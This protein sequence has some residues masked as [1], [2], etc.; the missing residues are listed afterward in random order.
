MVASRQHRISIGT[1][2]DPNTR[3]GKRLRKLAPLLDRVLG[4]HKLDD[5][6][7]K[8]GLSGLSAADFADQSL[9]A[10]DVEVIGGDSL[11]QRL[12]KTGPVIIVSNHPHGG[13][14]GLVLIKLLTALRPDSRIL[15]NFALKVFPELE[16][17]FLFVN[18]LIPSDPANRTGLR[19]SL[20]HLQDDGVL[21][22]FPAGRTSFYQDDLDCIAD[23]DWSRSVATLARKSGASVM[24]IRFTGLNSPLFY[25]LGSVW[26]RFRLLMLARELIKM[27]SRRIEVAVGAAAPTKKLLRYDDTEITEM[28]RVLSASLNMP[29]EQLERHQALEHAP[30][31]AG[32]CGKTIQK[33][34]EG[35][36]RHQQS[37]R[38]HGMVVGFARRAEIPEL[39][40]Q[41]MRD[42]ERTFRL[43]DE[44]SGESEDSDH[45]DDS[46]DHIFCWD[47]HNK[48]LVGAYRV[49]RG[50]PAAEGEPTYLHSVFQFEN[51]FF[52]NYNA[53]LELGRSFITPEYQ[54]SRHALDLLWRGIGSYLKAHPE[55][56]ALYGT[57]SLTQQYDSVSVQM[58][59]D[60]LIEPSSQVRPKFPLANR[61]PAEWYRFRRN[62]VIDLAKLNALVSARETDG[63]GVPVLL[64]H[65]AGL[66]AR[67]HAVGIDKQFADTPGLLLS[68]DLNQLPASKRKRYLT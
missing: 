2:A 64:R 18:P 41:I 47:E 29:V 40:R 20:R 65:Y 13:I 4:I 45:F 24:P 42:R 68:V 67:F 46:Y 34:I 50:R 52:E 62:Q 14:E 61:L 27:R 35:L 43:L 44:G 58:M 48:A 22:V 31:A 19:K 60:A 59:C 66:G 53:A 6:Y 57:V 21:V 12:P 7:Q 55:F 56:D 11:S 3:L 16:S 54:R 37:V 1:V 63:K 5:F 38:A 9:K 17:H 32:R 39:T 8:H 51:A 26:Y 23:S 30:L 49:C 28:L 10:L 36:P 25:R 15:A 33:E